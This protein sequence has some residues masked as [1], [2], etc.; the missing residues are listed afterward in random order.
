MTWHGVEELQ[1]NSI[2]ALVCKKTKRRVKLKPSNIS[3]GEFQ[4]KRQ[5]FASVEVKI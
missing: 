2:G 5:L 1:R 3:Y 4:K